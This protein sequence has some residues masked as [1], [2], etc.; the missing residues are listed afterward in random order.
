MSEAL[1]SEPLGSEPL[2][3]DARGTGSLGGPLR[4]PTVDVGLLNPLGHGTMEAA[5]T[6]DASWLQ[7]MLDAELALTRALIDADIVPAWMSPVCDALTDAGSLDIMA[8]A[9]QGRGGG[10]PVIPFVTHLGAAANAVRAGASDHIHVGAT[11]Q[12]ILDTAAMLIASR[13]TAEVSRQLRRLAGT[14]AGLAGEHRDTVMAGRTLGQQASPTSFGFV[15][16]GWLDAVLSI[17]QRVDGLRATLPVQLGGAVGNLA[18]LTEIAR[19]RRPAVPPRNSMDQVVQGFAGH[20]GLAVPSLSWHANRVVISELAAVLA[21]VTGV[22]GTFALD[23]TVLSR[24]EIAEVSERLGIGEGV[25]SAMPHKRNPVSSVL[26]VAAA[27]QTPGL[28]ATL[29]GSMLAEDQRPSGSWHAEWQSL[30]VLE[31]LTISAVTGAAALAARLDVDTDRMRANLDIT[32]GLVFSE[33]V[34]TILAEALGKTVAFDLVQRASREAFDTNRPVQV[35]LS[36]VLA[37]EGCDDE[38]RSQV[39]AAFAYGCDLGQST[40]GID[41]VLERHRAQC[42]EPFQAPADDLTHNTARTHT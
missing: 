20:L 7:A 8:I 13:V 1:G 27:R 31:G 9:A 40:A 21:S 36:G 35:V 25:S 39:W 12:D 17:L 3:S 42:G 29:F 30:R 10:N 41:R 2:G 32:D 22:A 28:V 16:A 38:L 26:I 19:S 37:A 11:S 24:T 15:A 4:R 33:R 18:V 5:L 6:S 23:V 34:T 14:L